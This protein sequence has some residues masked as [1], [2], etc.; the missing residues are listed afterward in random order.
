MRNIISAG[1]K[2]KR[3]VEFFNSIRQKRT[4][5][6]FVSKGCKLAWGRL[7][8]VISSYSVEGVVIQLMIENDNI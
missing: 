6:F 8:A 1:P 2:K 7:R 3:M 4:S 5:Q